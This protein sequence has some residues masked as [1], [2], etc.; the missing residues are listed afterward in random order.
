MN[1][2]ARNIGGMIL[3]GKKIKLFGDNTCPI[4]TLST[5][6]P[7]WN[8]LVGSEMKKCTDKKLSVKLMDIEPLKIF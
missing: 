1:E 4:A 2:W 7:T 8:L 3:A 5:T 6:N